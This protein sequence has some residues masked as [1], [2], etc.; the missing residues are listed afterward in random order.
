[1]EKF[2][3]VASGFVLLLFNMFGADTINYLVGNILL[4][5]LSAILVFAI[6]RRLGGSGMVSLAIA[7]AVA[8]SR[9]A[10][11]AATQVIGPLEGL[12]LPLLLGSLYST[13]RA[14]ECRASA[15]QW[16]WIAIGLTF[17]LIHTHERY[18]VVGAWLFLAFLLLPNVRSLPRSQLF[19][20]LGACVLLPIIYITYKWIALDSSFL[21]GT[22]GTHVA[23]KFSQMFSHF[24]QAFFS[25]LGFNN[26][27]EYLI[28]V[29]LSSLPWFPVWLLALSLA[30]SWFVLVCT[31]IREAIRV[32]MSEPAQHP[33]I[34]PLLFLILGGFVLFPAILTI[35]MEQR[36]IFAT[37]IL[38]MLLLPVSLSKLYTNRRFLTTSLMVGMVC[39]SIALDTVIMKHFDQLYFSYAAHFAELVKRD[40]VDKGVEKSSPVVFFIGAEQCSWTIGNGG[41]FRVYEGSQRD[42][43]CFNSVDDSLKENFPKNTK[44]YKV[45]PDELKDVTNLWRDAKR[46]SYGKALAH[47]FLD[48]FQDGKISN[49][50]KVSSPNGMGVFPLSL[51]DDLRLRNTL[52][53]VSG[54]SY[55]FNII[56][57]D[58]TAELSFSASM[59]YPSANSARAVVTIVEEGGMKEHVVY[60]R[61]LVPPQRGGK[62]NFEAVVIPLSDY[63]GKSI[64]LSFMAETPEGSSNGHW[65]AFTEPKIVENREV[66]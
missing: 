17:L 18:V 50:I 65:V 41:F 26:G 11:Y 25:I 3:P 21:I 24:L 32:K 2:R 51:Q 15:W 62:L 53:V 35:R 63:V 64:S 33:L 16:C 59:V 42:V 12:A 60:L 31:G 45:N 8:T 10:T 20:L 27:P 5:G 34:W 52:T 56:V 54:F 28:G 48:S 29:R 14:S 43:K 55:Q 4:L 57:V 44:F 6:S 49:L 36:W 22:G 7:L 38:V 61:D 40:I 39:C 13:I 66:D 46:R 37:F 58:P 47:D 1:M 19:V 9:F 30:L 23:F